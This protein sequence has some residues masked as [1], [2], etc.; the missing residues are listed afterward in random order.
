MSRGQEI[1][2]AGSPRVNIFSIST[3]HT[4]LSHTAEF[5][6]YFIAAFDSTPI[7]AGALLIIAI[8][9]PLHC[10]L[11]PISRFAPSNCQ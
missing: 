7:F 10:V 3:L 9:L 6:F 1:L 5:D 4:E 8:P 2:G 11:I